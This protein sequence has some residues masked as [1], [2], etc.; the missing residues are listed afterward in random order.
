[1]VNHRQSNNNVH[2]S[3]TNNQMVIFQSYLPIK[4]TKKNIIKLYSHHHHQP[5]GINPGLTR[6]VITNIINHYITIITII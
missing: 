3:S 4:S 1:M 5:K 2:T 6:I